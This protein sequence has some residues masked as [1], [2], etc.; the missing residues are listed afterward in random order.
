MSFLTAIGSWLLKIFLGGLFGKFQSEAEEKA[1]READ[2]A[3]LAVKTGEEAREFER[4]VREKQ[5][6]VD[7]AFK[8]PAKEDDPFRFKQFNGMK[9]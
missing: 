5:D 3:K 2:A 6:A 8:A 4:E 9:D 7:E 1:K